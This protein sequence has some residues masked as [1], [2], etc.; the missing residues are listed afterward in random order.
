MLEPFDVFNMLDGPK[1]TRDKRGGDEGQLQATESATMALYREVQHLKPVPP[2]RFANKIKFTQLS[3]EKDK[4]KDGCGCCGAAK[5]GC[6]GAT[7]EDASVH[8][9]GPRMHFMV[10]QGSKACRAPA[11]AAPA[12][13]RD[14]LCW[15]PALVRA[16]SRAGFLLSG[17]HLSGN[18]NIIIYG[19]KAAVTN[20]GGGVANGGGA[21]DV[22]AAGTSSGKG[23]AAG[24]GGSNGKGG[25]GGKK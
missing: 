10:R 14:D 20:S 19:D 4:K 2:A 6:C 7:T 21:G 3:K 11:R 16:S 13:T 23:G 1:R 25:K 12:C 18:S 17:D 8:N 24:G 15:Y 5:C 22:H 9:T